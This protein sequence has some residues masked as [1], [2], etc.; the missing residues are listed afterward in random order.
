MGGLLRR[1][2]PNGRPVDGTGSP[3]HWGLLQAPGL[4][5]RARPRYQYTLIECFFDFLMWSVNV[6]YMFAICKG[7]YDFLQG[8]DGCTWSTWEYWSTGQA[9]M[10]GA[11]RSPAS[12]NLG[13]WRP[14]RSVHGKWPICR[15]F[16]YY[17]WWFSMAML[18]NQMVLNMFRLFG[19]YGNLWKEVHLTFIDICHHV[20]Y[21]TIKQSEP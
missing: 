4:C 18:D 2:S 11:I 5:L 10:V 13:R 8:D 12:R 6:C 9:K 20:L 1:P 14:W 16:T 3:S 21:V 19:Q 7:C 15:W 17:T